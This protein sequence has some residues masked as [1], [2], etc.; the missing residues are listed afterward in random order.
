[1]HLGTV[2]HGV[3]A[4]NC[5]PEDK[6]LEGMVVVCVRKVGTNLDLCIIDHA[7]NNLFWACEGV[8]VDSGDFIDDSKQQRHVT[9]AQGGICVAVELYVCSEHDWLVSVVACW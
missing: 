2:E 5:V 8:V 1:M 6:I 9:I 3:G 4:A 7:L